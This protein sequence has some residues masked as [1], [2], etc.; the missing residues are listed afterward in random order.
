MDRNDIRAVI[1]AYN[2]L[3]KELLRLGI[4]QIDTE[5]LVKNVESMLDQH[6][7]IYFRGP[8]IRGKL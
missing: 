6:P 1:E 4:T 3:R 5:D 2:D 7:E 8:D